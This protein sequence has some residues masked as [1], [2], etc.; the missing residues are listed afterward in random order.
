MIS[1]YSHAKK[2]HKFSLT[3]N[4]ILFILDASILLYLAIEK[5]PKI[6]FV[7]VTAVLIVNTLFIFF[8]GLSSRDSQII[9]TEKAEEHF[10]MFT[11]L[12][13]KTESVVVAIHKA[14]TEGY[15]IFPFMLELGNVYYRCNLEHLLVAYEKFLLEKYSEVDK[16]IK[17]EV[18]E[19]TTMWVNQL[20]TLREERSRV[21]SLE[22]WK[23]FENQRQ[24]A[25]SP[26]LRSS[27]GAKKI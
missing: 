21:E 10:K 17:E 18:K 22:S 9:A 5:D 11:C 6:G 23:Y 8:A 27:P 24:I 12:I 3:L 2:L 7:P 1:E 14:E 16:K 20:A 13:L 25:P 15:P 4:A 19:A 26:P